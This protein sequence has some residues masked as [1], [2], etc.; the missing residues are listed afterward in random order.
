MAAA[1]LALALFAAI[2]PAFADPPSV[3]QQAA[4]ASVVRG[5]EAQYQAALIRE[6]RLAD[7]REQRLIAE[8][9]ARLTRARAA[10]DAAR[11]DAAAI[12]TELAAARDEYATLVETIAQRDASARA[13]IDSYRREAEN[14]VAR[15]S[16]EMRAALERFADGDRIG[17]WPVIEQETQA[18]VRARLDAAERAAAADLEEVERLRREM[19]EQ[20]P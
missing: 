4:D 19:Q 16:P 20:N 6:R 7:D 12:Q 15:A 9:E 10:A 2:T 11:G 17:A 5:L 3:A 1:G 18:R 8:A 14:L 13:E